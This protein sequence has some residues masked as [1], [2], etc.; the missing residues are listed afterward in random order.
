[1]AG[2]IEAW[3]ARDR[4]S[5]DAISG[6]QFLHHNQSRP[7][8]LAWG[9]DE[10]SLPNLSLL[11]LTPTSMKRQSDGVMK[12]MRRRREKARKAEAAAKPSFRRELSSEGK[13]Y[14][15]AK[16]ANEPPPPPPAEPPPPPAEPAP[17]PAEPDLL[18]VP[19]NDA[20]DY[21]D[22]KSDDERGGCPRPTPAES[23]VPLQPARASSAD[24]EVASDSEYE[25]GDSGLSEEQSE[26]IAAA[27]QRAQAKQVADEKRS[28]AV[29][30]QVEEAVREFK[31]KKAQRAAERAAALEAQR[32]AEKAERQRQNAEPSSLRTKEAEALEKMLNALPLNA[33]LSRPL[34][35]KRSLKRL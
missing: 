16:K 29:D 1:M 12:E 6:K 21:A 22:I 20:C 23:V 13:A 17:P 4:R 14:K 30:P 7:K 31:K 11:S 35:Q 28:Q 2:G 9:A 32:A 15:K 5:T 10:M 27:L 25:E 3:S 8:T 34:N 33:S 19:I 24:D 18:N 26:R